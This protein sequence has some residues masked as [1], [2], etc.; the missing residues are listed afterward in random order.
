[1]A[2]VTVNVVEPETPPAAAVIVLPP[3]LRPVAR[4][5][6]SMVATVVSDDVQVAELLRSPVEPSVIRGRGR[7]LF[8]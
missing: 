4:P 7:E 2:L 5:W 3:M 6:L 8:R 1:M